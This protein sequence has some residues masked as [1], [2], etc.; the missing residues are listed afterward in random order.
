MHAKAEYFQHIKDFNIVLNLIHI[1]T[2]FR[3]IILI[4]E[5][6]RF[7]YNHIPNYLGTPWSLKCGMQ[8]MTIYSC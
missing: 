1:L 4:M 3:H 2:T 6:I 7:F 5:Q 8:T